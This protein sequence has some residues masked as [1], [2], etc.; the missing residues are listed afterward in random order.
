MPHVPNNRSPANFMLQAISW[1]CETGSLCHSGAATVHCNATCVGL[2][3]TS[4]CNAKPLRPIY[5]RKGKLA[6]VPDELMSSSGKISMR[7]WNRVRT[8]LQADIVRMPNSGSLSAAEI[9][10][11][12]QGWV[13]SLIIPKGLY[14]PPLDEPRSCVCRRDTP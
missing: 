1:L 7:R 9:H 6:I 10:A 2:G 13:P 3:A 14:P 5:F 11:Q 8:M 12:T 4:D